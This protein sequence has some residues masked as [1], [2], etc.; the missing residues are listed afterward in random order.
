M[1]E[2][3]VE[4]PSLRAAWRLW[5]K[6][7]C[8]GFGGPAAQIALMHRELV[9][10]RRWLGERRFLHALNFCMLLP[11]P[12]AQQLATYLGWL[13]WRTPGGLLAGL[14]F[15][16]PGLLFL[17]LL[18]WLYVAFGDSL[19]VSGVFYGVKPAVVAVVVFALF[20]MGRRMLANG[21]MWALASA[22]FVAIAGFSAPF[23]A[24]V[25]GAALFGV[26]GGRLWPAWFV[27][28][29]RETVRQEGQAAW[30]D[31]AAPTPLH[32]RFR[33]RRLCGVLLLGA[34]LWSLPMFGLLM[35]L[36]ADHVLVQM[37]W[38][39]TKAALLTFGGAY[40][41]LPYVVQAAVSR[42]HWLSAAQMVDGLALGEANPGPLIMVVAFV[43]FVAG[44]EQVFPAL[45]WRF[46]AGA[47]AALWVTWLVFL[48][49]FV[50]VFAGAPLAESSR[51]WR[52]F[53]APL[54]AIGAAVVGVIAN[55]ALFFA[56]HVFWP[57]GFGG[58]VDAVA[59]GV[60]LLAGVLLGAGR[61]G[62]MTTLALCA[63]SGLL[64]QYLFGNAVI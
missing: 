20:R 5:L 9:E 44:Y 51:D 11:G 27:S 43:G 38:F 62:V 52:L 31:D 56:G 53:A 40:A 45:E 22:A 13:L 25:L 2:D 16:L 19:W 42:Y 60:A 17:L 58:E 18:S 32:A 35:T 33:W 1:R 61:C 12:E 15:L 29:G 55:M 21:A 28:S 54:Q 37:G 36:G 48:P 4:A 63:G 14:L 46:F 49:S 23:P 7:G 39:F 59:L 47:M 24:V 64:L 3:G 57:Q 34:A 6:L 30:L 10:R 41:V 8:M 26:A 50:L